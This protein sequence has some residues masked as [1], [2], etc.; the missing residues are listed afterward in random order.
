MHILTIPAF[1][2]NYFWLLVNPDTRQAAVVDPGDAAPVEKV[3]AEH[4]LTLSTILITHH[5]PDH[6]GGVEALKAHWHAIVYGPNNPSL[7]FITHTLSEGDSIDV[8]DHEFTILNVPGHTLDHIAYF[9]AHPAPIL[10]CGDTLFA[11][12]CGRLFEGTAEQ[13]LNSLAKIDALPPLTRIYCAHEYTASNLRFASTVEPDNLALQQRVADTAKL[14]EQH[15]ATVP[16]TLALEQQT[17][18]FLRWREPAVKLAAQ[19]RAGT[20]LDAT[21]VFRHIRQWKDNF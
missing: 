1:T 2:D 18:P 20:T 9:C 19:H 10:F 14:R 6:V 3:L 15:Q 8:F 12:G 5:H 16:S 7:A 21:G 17:N 13:M 4:E 11:G